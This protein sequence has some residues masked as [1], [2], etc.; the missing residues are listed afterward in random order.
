MRT[1]AAL[2]YELWKG[3]RDTYAIQRMKEDEVFYFRVTGKEI[4]PNEYLKH[5]AGEE[6]MGLYPLCNDFCS[7]AALDIDKPDLDLTRQASDLLPKP[8]YIERSRSGNYHVWM[9]FQSPVHIKK[10]AERCRECIDFVRGSGDLHCNLYPLPS[11][12]IG[13][14]IALPLQPKLLKQGLTAFIDDEGNPIGDA[15]QFLRELKYTELEG[16]ILDDP[17]IRKLWAGQGKTQGDTSRSGY[18]FSFA[19]ALLRRN[20]P[21]EEVKTW[22]RQRPHVHSVLDEYLDRTIDKASAKIGDISIPVRSWADIKPLTRGEFLQQLSSRLVID[23]PQRQQLDIFFAAIIANLKTSGRPVWLLIIGPPGCGKTLPMMAIQHSP[24]T[25][26]CSSFRPTA[27]ISG[28]GIRGG[29]DMSLIP[30]LNGKILLVKDLSSLL[31][32][33]R[34]IVNEIFGL[35]RDAYD[36]ACSRAFGTGV[37]RVY[38]SRFGFIGATT[39]DV[40]AHWGLNV[41]L[42]E[43]FLRFRVKST[44]EQVYAKIDKALESLLEEERVDS[45]IEEASLGFL[46]YLKRDAPLPKLSH[47][48]EIGRLAQLGAILRTAVARGARSQQVLVVPEWEEATRYAKQLAKMALALA[49]IRDKETNDNEEMEDLKILVRDGMDARMEKICKMVYTHPE[50]DTGEIALRLNLPSFTVRSCL[51]DLSVARIVIGSRNSYTMRWTITPHLKGQLNVFK[52]WTGE[53]K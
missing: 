42:G 33:N 34:D 29:E 51:D 19:R 45:V 50:L 44:M 9:F 43:R 49:Y 31:S 48:K 37:E 16:S 11:K 2:M 24:Y 10:L 47:T 6:V 1:L 38:K 5:L 13:L 32:Q 21:R 25:Y 46:K 53:I 27:L 22:L 15:F 30:K 39:P 23:K 26:A 14:L 8:N 52:L 17:E 40:D 3:R 7:F 20:F 35:L 41:R 28:W 36:G 18:D 4:T 12:G